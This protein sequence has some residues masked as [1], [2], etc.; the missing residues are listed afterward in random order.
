MMS[1]HVYTLSSLDPTGAIKDDTK[2]PYFDSG[3]GGSEA[4]FPHEM[5]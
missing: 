4:V 5:K 1:I 2:T 3:D